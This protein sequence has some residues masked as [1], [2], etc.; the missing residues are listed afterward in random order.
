MNWLRQSQFEHLRLKASLQEVFN[1]QTQNVIKLHTTLFKYPNTNQATQKC[2][3]CSHTN[4]ILLTN[5]RTVLC[6]FHQMQLYYVFHKWTKL[7]S[8]DCEQNILS[9]AYHDMQYVG[10]E[11]DHENQ[12]LSFCCAYKTWKQ[13]T[14]CKTYRSSSGFSSEK[15]LRHILYPLLHYQIVKMVKKK[16]VSMYHTKNNK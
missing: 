8:P 11:S 3:T 7:N 2:I 1:L 13:I 10:R 14:Y 9:V 4:I 15:P 5:Q 12:C 16:Y 6:S